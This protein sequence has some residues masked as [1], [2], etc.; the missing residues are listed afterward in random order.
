MRQILAIITI[1][2]LLNV[3][4]VWYSSPTTNKEPEAL[5]AAYAQEENTVNTDRKSVLGLMKSLRTDPKPISVPKTG[6]KVPIITYHYVRVVPNPSLDRLGER[7]SV[8][9]S[10]FRK[11]L[12]YLKSNNYTPITLKDLDLALENKSS[13]PNKP[14]VLTF[15]DGYEDFYTSAYPLL[16]EFNTK[17]TLFMVAGFIGR[18]DQLYLTDSQLKEL[19]SSGLVEIGVHS[20]SHNDMSGGNVN[21]HKETADAKQKLE[22]VVGHS[23]DY[24]AYPYGKFNEQVIESVKSAGFRLSASTYGGFYHSQ[25]DRFFLYRNSVGNNFARFLT[26]LGEKTPT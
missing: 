20:Y 15:D 24:F 12:D 25:T 26:S 6:I 4:F 8:T 7:L 19:D 13:L 9:P 1:F 21:L 16:K 17:A 18:T 23:L 11:E 22:S 3:G 10:L 5:K 2:V 14:V